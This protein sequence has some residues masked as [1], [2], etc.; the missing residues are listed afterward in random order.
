MMHTLFF[1]RSAPKMEEIIYADHSNRLKAMANGARKETV[2]IKATPISPSAN[3]VYAN[4]VISINAK[5]R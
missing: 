3:K 2:H 4:E 1:L 5:L